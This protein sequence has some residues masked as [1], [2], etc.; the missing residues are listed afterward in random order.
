MQAAVGHKLEPGCSLV[1]QQ[2]NPFG[3]RRMFLPSPFKML[4][5]FLKTGSRPGVFA[6]VF[7]DFVKSY[8]V[9]IIKSK[10]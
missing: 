4:H 3:L 5:G 10:A 7:L 9:L 1:G 2:E 8:F 6:K